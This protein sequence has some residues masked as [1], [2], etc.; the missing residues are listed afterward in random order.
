MRSRDAQCNIKESPLANTLSKSVEKKEVIFLS[1]GH[2]KVFCK[3]G[4]PV[5]AISIME[6]IP[7]NLDTF[8][9]PEVI[10]K[11]LQDNCDKGINK[12]IL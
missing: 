4:L 12:L 2:C 5:Y 8:P 7:A 3:F 6:L 10:K 1:Q 11:T 9:T